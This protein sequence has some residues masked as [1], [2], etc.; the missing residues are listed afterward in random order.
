MKKERS[1]LATTER[2]VVG[3]LEDIHY[4][5][6]NRVASDPQEHSLPIF[7]QIQAMTFE[8]FRSERE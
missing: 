6:R 1:H 4:Q 7:D 2:V 3:K 8:S 5:L